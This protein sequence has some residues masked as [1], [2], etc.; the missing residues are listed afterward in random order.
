MTTEQL[1]KLARQQ[2]KDFER[3]SADIKAEHFTE[4]GTQHAIIFHFECK[5]QGDK[6]DVV[7]DKDSGA[8]VQLAHTPGD[9]GGKAN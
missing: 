3:Q 1:R 8:F 4:S 2:L 6:I 7:L 9:I 5:A